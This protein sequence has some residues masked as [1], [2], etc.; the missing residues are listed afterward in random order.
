MHMLHTSTV[1]GL[2]DGSVRHMTH[3][4]GSN[5]QLSPCAT[6]AH[7][8]AITAVLVINDMTIATDDAQGNV[9][10]SRLDVTMSSM[11][12]MQPLQVHGERVTVIAAC[13][14]DA[15]HGVV[16][17]AAHNG[18]IHQW[19]SVDSDCWVM[20]AGRRTRAA[21]TATP[22]TRRTSGPTGMANNWHSCAPS[23]E[24]TVVGW[25]I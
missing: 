22:N 15:V 5:W 14:L 24:P 16:L 11:H 3:N 20:R 17:T 19:A 6:K 21:A 7:E 9:Y 4:S 25:L 8:T 12:C 23:I 10:V 1:V 2:A 13:K 18:V